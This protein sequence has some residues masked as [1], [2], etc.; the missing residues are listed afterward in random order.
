MNVDWRELKYEEAFEQEVRGLERRRISTACTLEEIESLLES[1]YKLDGDNWLGRG[2][3][4][5][6]VMSATI[7]AYE[8]FLAEWRREACV[9]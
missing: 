7:A 5:D 2:E 1:L 8:H 6:I 9:D 3:V 4:Q